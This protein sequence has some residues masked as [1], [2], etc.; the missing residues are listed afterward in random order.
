MKNNLPLEPPAVKIKKNWNNGPSLVVM[1]QN[2]VTGGGPE[3]NYKELT[4]TIS[5]LHIIQKPS[6]GR[7]APHPNSYFF[8]YHS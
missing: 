6:G 7:F 3:T 4:N 5:G 2:N 8:H 1:C